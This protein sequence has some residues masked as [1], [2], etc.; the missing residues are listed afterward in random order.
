MKQKINIGN[1]RFEAL[2]RRSNSSE[3]QALP[4]LEKQN[5]NLLSDSSKLFPSIKDFPI[6]NF[7]FPDIT[8][9]LENQ[10]VLFKRIIKKLCEPY[11]QN[12]PDALVC[13]ESFGYIFGVPM[14]YE[15]NC[16]MILARKKGKLPRRKL[17]RD[18]SMIYSS[19][20]TIEIHKDAVWKGRR[21]ALVDDFLA[22]GGTAI[23]TFEIIKELGGETIG[24]SFV[25]EVD[26]L[27]GR[28]KLEGNGV[29]VH[30]I[31][32]LALNHINGIWE[33]TN[34]KL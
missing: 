19:Q 15:L 9:I 11:L 24:S 34:T 20:K 5:C 13:I 16:K 28:S 17:S 31:Y 2:S 25:V 18:Y 7:I 23:A 32:N 14:A 8:P 6:D 10:P 29:V 22:S 27:D 12:P 1:K 30:N 33:I 4:N 26:H 3:S 21:V